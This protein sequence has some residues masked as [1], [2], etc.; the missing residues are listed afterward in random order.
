MAALVSLLD[1]YAKPV[2]ETGRLAPSFT[3]D[4]EYRALIILIAFDIHAKM[5]LGIEQIGTPRLKLLQFAAQRP[6]LVPVLKEWSAT[7]K[8]ADM[9]ILVPQ[10]LRRAY[11]TDPCY[12]PIVDYFVASEVFQRTPTHILKG[13]AFEK[14]RTSI[15]TVRK[16]SLFVSELTILD[17]L[18]SIKITNSMLGAS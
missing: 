5:R 17:Q 10:H 15:N 13:K 2:V 3:Y 6:S 16:R 18:Q 11:L 14:H 9:S 1:G 7:R 4:F 12:P 8:D